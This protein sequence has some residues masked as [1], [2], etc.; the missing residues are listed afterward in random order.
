MGVEARIGWVS[1]VGARV[2]WGLGSS[3]VGR[4]GNGRMSKGEDGE[5]VEVGEGLKVLQYG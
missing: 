5:G 2:G 4:V 3:G 1:T